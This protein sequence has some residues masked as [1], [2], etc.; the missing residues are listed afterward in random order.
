MAL[1]GIFHAAL[2][3]QAG[4]ICGG[5]IG[6]S[7]V[8]EAE[9][10]A[11]AEKFESQQPPIIMLQNIPSAVDIRIQQAM[12]EIVSHTGVKSN[13]TVAPANIPNA[14]AYINNSGARLLLYNPT[15]MENVHARVCKDWGV[16]GIVAHEVGHHMQ[17]HILRS[18]DMNF[19]QLELEADDFTGFVLYRMGA[20]LEEAQRSTANLSQ[21]QDTATHPGTARRLEAIKAGWMRARGVAVDETY[22]DAQRQQRE[23]ASPTP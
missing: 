20:T 21:P 3:L 7:L 9:A 15:F 11:E 8:A 22:H 6:Q 19:H 16:Y 5:I 10:E 17:G 4:P 23:A 18:M 12:E 14:L 1:S 13:F 2:L